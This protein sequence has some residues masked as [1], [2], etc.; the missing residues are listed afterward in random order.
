[1]ADNDDIRDTIRGIREALVEV[2]DATKKLH[3]RLHKGLVTHGSTLGFDDDEVAL[4]AGGGTPKTNP[5][6]GG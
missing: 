4:L 6:G 2:E 1:M 3:R 5:G